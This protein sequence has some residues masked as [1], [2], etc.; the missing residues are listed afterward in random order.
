MTVRDQL[1]L[2]IAAKFI[3][4]FEGGQSHDGLF[5]VYWDPNG[6]VYTIGYGHTGREVHAGMHPWT[7]GQ[8]LRQLRRDAKASLLAA[9]A[10]VRRLKPNRYELAALTSAG[11]NLGTGIFDRSHTLGAAM[12]HGD[13][14]AIADAFLLYDRDANGTVLAGLQRRRQ[15]ERRLFNHDQRRSR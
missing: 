13:R 9:V 1:A 2:R 8:A 5:H 15:A 11:F 10:N 14:R 3:A 12:H 6:N 7:K 4:G